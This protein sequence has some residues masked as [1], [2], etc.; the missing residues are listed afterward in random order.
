MKKSHIVIYVISLVL[1]L[2]ACAREE[3]TAPTATVLVTAVASPTMSPTPRPTASPTPEP[4]AIVPA[5][6]VSDQPLAGDGRITID[7]VLI[8]QPGWLVLHA[9]RDGQ[10]AEVLGFTNIDAGI[11]DDLVVTIDP[12]QATP[13]LAAMLHVDAGEAG[14]FEFPGPDQPLQQ[15]STVVMTSFA[16]DFQMTL[17]TISAADQPV[18]EDGLVRIESA[19]VPMPGWLLIFADADGA[20]GPLLGQTPLE[21]GVNEGVTVS[22]PWRQATPRLYAALHQDNGRPGRLDY[23]GE[24]L[25]LLAGG[26]P[27][28]VPF[29][30]TLP[31]DVL[32]LDQPIVDGSVVIERAISYGPGWLAVHLDEDGQPGL[33]VGSA[34]LVDGVNEQVEVKIAVST[35]TPQLHVRLHQDSEPGNDF[36]F[37]ASDPPVIYNDQL[38]P[39]FTFRTNMGNYLITRDQ[40]ISSEG[41]SPVTVTVPYVVTDV[42]AWVVIHAYA[43]GQRGDIL[44]VS[45]VAPGIT[46]DVPVE[47]SAAQAGDTLHAVLYQDAGTVGEFDFPNGPDIPLQRNRSVIHAPFVLLMAE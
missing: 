5:I 12:L 20:P 15:D 38:P 25:P 2:V 21:E 18:G 8:P 47:L 23:P 4:T 16:L 17:P 3:A 24:D 19:T 31:P 39:P 14:S 44:G 42:P 34:P 9:E 41:D 28:V 46:R 33:I 13:S 40:V 11:N 29:V 1:G 22:I 36:N 45:P 32:V 43:E 10:V 30:A 27:V 26:L 35:A 37:P 6:N 7:R